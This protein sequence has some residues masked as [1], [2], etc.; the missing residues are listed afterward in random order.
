[1]IGLSLSHGSRRISSFIFQSVFFLLLIL[2]NVYSFSSSSVV[3]FSVPTILPWVH[4]KSF[5][6]QLLH[7]LVAKFPSGSYVFYF[8]A[9]IL[10]V[11][12]SFSFVSSMFIV[13]HW[14][15]FIMAALKSLSDNSNSFLCGL[16]FLCGTGWWGLILRWTSDTPSWL[17]VTPP[18]FQ[19]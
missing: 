14:N 6:I 5:F 13:V 4:L 11:E 19:V 1:M 3:I 17:P 8:F 2:G 7:R 15:I 16:H 10:F 9:E 12:A 18:C